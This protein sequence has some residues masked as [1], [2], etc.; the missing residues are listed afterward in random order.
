MPAAFLSLGFATSNDTV[1]DLFRL[2]GKDI[3][4]CRILS[5][6]LNIY[7]FYTQRAHLGYHWP[8]RPPLRQRCTIAVP[9]RWCGCLKMKENSEEERNKA[10][11][12]T[13]EPKGIVNRTS[14]LMMIAID[15]R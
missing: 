15:M 5:N 2:R 7:A 13:H 11:E 4:C 6:Q 3:F 12:K 9:Q 10:T 8:L 14:I 1:N